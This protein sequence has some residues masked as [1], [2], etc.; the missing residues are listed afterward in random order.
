MSVI[1]VQ[2]WVSNAGSHDD[3]RSVQAQNI[4]KILESLFLRNITPRHAARVV[5]EELLPLIKA[6]P[7]EPRIGSIWAVVCHAARELGSD[8][9]ISVLLVQF[10]DALQTIEVKDDDGGDIRKD[11]GGYFWKDLPGFALTFR[12]YGI[13]KTSPFP[14]L[15]LSPRLSR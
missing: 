15:I 9:S 8:R 12:E 13:S 6:N 4:I 1:S 11:W 3:H 7:A 10:L 14:S 5:N 2:S